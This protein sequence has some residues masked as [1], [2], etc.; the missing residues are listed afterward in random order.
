M[1]PC[2]VQVMSR[3]SHP[4]SGVRSGSTAGRL[5]AAQ[6]PPAAARRPVIKVAY[7]SLQKCGMVAWFSRACSRQAKNGGAWPSSLSCRRRRQPAGIHAH[8]PILIEF[9]L[10]LQCFDFDRRAR[11]VQMPSYLHLRG[12]DLI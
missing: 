1:D 12:A 4:S 2:I 10:A 8:A 7:V 6:L 9:V 11:V 5:P 3:S